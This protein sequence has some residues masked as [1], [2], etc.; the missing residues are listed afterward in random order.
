MA[1]LTNVTTLLLLACISHQLV[2]SEA[3]RQAVDGGDEGWTED[4]TRTS[5]A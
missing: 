5:Q 4:K 3:L 2:M 1:L